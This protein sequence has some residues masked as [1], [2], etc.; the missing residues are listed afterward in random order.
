MRAPK[1]RPSPQDLQEQRERDY[2]LLHVN[3]VHHSVHYDSSSLSDNPAVD[4]VQSVSDHCEHCCPFPPC[5]NQVSMSLH[6]DSSSEA[7]S[8]VGPDVAICNVLDEM[9][10]APPLCYSEGDPTCVAA[11]LFTNLTEVNVPPETKIL[12]E[13]RMPHY[14]ADRK[15][16][17]LLDR[18]LGNQVSM[19]GY[20]WAKGPQS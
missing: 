2:L 17:G 19:D 13:D 8:G 16:K 12:Y 9:E 6:E 10:D 7:E 20:L 18:G 3:R 14:R 1:G 4:A 5:F 11:S 15:Y